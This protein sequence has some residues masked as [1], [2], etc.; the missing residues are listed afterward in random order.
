MPNP[1]GG[2]G[3]LRVANEKQNS[4]ESLMLF[5]RQSGLPKRQ[6]T[7]MRKEWDK[8][9]AATRAFLLSLPRAKWIEAIESGQLKQLLTDAEHDAAT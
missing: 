1:F 4:F 9:D 6:Q 3:P 5:L 8:T 7:T 2:R